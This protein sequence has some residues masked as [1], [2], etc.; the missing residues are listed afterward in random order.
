MSNTTDS[1]RLVA[2][3]R[4][5]R[6]FRHDLG[7]NGSQLNQQITLAR[8]IIRFLDQTSLLQHAA[9]LEDQVLI[10]SRIQD[11]AYYEPDS[12]GIPD[13]AHWCVRQWLRLSQ[14]HTEDVGVL[15]GLYRMPSPLR[16]GLTSIGL[17][18]AWL[19]RSQKSLA[20]IQLEEGSSS[21]SVSG[22][23]GRSASSDPYDDGANEANARRHG[24]DYVDA[25]GTLIP[26]TEYLTRAVNLA[27]REGVLGGHLLSLVRLRYLLHQQSTAYHVFRRQKLI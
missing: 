14:Q 19:F 10:V 23:Y 15:Q 27:E 24:A 17:G 5:V 21:S 12:G 4:E 26:A 20:K 6:R 25:R 11:L 13:I 22:G 8:S 18:Q 7:S 16:V 2:I 9:R 1:Q 3:I